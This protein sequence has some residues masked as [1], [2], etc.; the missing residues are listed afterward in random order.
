MSELADRLDSITEIIRKDFSEKDATRERSIP[1]CRE[2][3]RYCG[4]AIRAIHRHEFD[5]AKEMLSTASELLREVESSIKNC[6]ELRNTGFLHDAQKELTEG[7]V[8]LALITGE[9]LPAPDELSVEYAAYLNG[10]GEAVGELRRYL[11]DGLRKGDQ[12]RGEDLLEAM[13]DIYNILVT[14]DF[15][16]AITGGLRRTT[17]NF[18]G[19]LEKTRSDLT[20][21]IQQK[22]L[23]NKLGKYYERRD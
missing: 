20:L 14:I 15:P 12:S 13:D 5:K 17:D 7:Y 3:I 1:L 6:S 22:S 23:E 2:A 16:D 10:L 8:T 11:L 18:R 21:M 19:V 4:N 9:P